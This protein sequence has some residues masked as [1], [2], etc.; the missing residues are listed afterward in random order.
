MIGRNCIWVGLL[1]VVALAG[2]DY[3]PKKS[4]VGSLDSYVGPLP[5]QARRSPVTVV[6][7]PNSEVP[8]N[9]ADSEASKRREVILANVIKLMELA[10]DHPGGRNFEMATENLNELFDTGTK[11]ADY[12]HT[13][14]SR[15]FLLQKIRALTNQ[16]PD[17][18]VKSLSSPKFTIR[19]AR[20]IEDCMMYHAVATRIAGEGDDLTRVRRIFDWLVRNI[21]LVPA[22]SLAT[23]KYPQAR[24]RP[25]DVLIR[26]MATE[27]GSW[28]ERGWLFMSLCRQIGIDVGIVTY[29]PRRPMAM[30]NAA[31]QPVAPLITW[32][33]AAIIDDKPY[34]FDPRIGLEIPSVDGASVATI[35]EVIAHPE[36]LQ[37][38]DLPGES[39]LG[40]T[41]ADLAGSPTKIGFLVDSSIG[42][43]SPR[44]RL[45]QGQLRGKSRTILFRD[46]A[47]Q[48]KHFARALGSRF[49]G[50]FLWNLPIQIEDLL[51]SN[52]DFVAATQ[53]SLQFFD[54]KYPLLTARTAQLR[55]ELVD[56]T[57]KYVAFRFAENP[58]VPPETQRGLD[59]YATYFLGLSHLD[60]GNTDQAEY[61]FRKLL[62][63]VPEPGPGRFFYYMLRWG[64]LNNL[65]RILEKKGDAAGAIAYYNKADISRG[66]ASPQHHGDLLRARRLVWNNP[67]SE[68]TQELAAAPPDKS[69]TPELIAAPKT[70]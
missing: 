69:P 57:N 60:R 9:N 13:S 56:A 42:Y 18:I 17:P 67:M 4:R 40:T 68:P 16:D 3:S 15:A 36:I 64:A 31:N 12:A 50:V 55:G 21:L 27:S 38:L 6:E 23:S 20:H 14:E 45:L 2:C 41:A 54:G 10:S 24:V 25:A 39:T 1:A 66:F 52:P 35:E 61:L 49:G 37:R 53:A 19:D 11:P 59:V 26:G 32:V 63:M 51:F 62:D 43:M 48:S 7:D 8:Q 28:S 30:G 22:E 46:P 29:T 47:E 65:G 44:M 70:P 58:D 33:A 34:L 5:N